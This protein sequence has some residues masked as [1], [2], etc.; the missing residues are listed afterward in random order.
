MLSALHTC[1]P[2]AQAF[3]AAMGQVLLVLAEGRACQLS[4][5]HTQAAC[6]ALMRLQWTAA[7]CAVLCCR[8]VCL[9]QGVPHTRPCH[10]TSAQSGACPGSPC[11]QALQ[12]A[13]LQHS[14]QLQQTGR[15][16]SS[17]SP[18]Q[19]TLLQRTCCL[20]GATTPYTH[21]PAHMQA[22]TTSS[23]THAHAC[24]PVHTHAPPC[25]RARCPTAKRV[26]CLQAAVG[27]KQQYC[28]ASI[29]TP[30]F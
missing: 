15:G 13:V 26:L 19:T 25:S 28:V 29:H 17:P 2:P 11:T 5:L 10:E 6:V 12:A 16:S 3:C 24:M 8:S 23:P 20:N 7:C 1:A 9:P 14:W 27:N 18:A 21:P 30:S 22:C 4:L